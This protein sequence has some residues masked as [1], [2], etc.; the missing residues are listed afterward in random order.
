[1]RKKTVRD[2]DVRGKRALVRVDFNVPLDK[3]TRTVLDDTRIRAALPTIA[4]LR[5]QG[6]RVILCS[7][8]G[9]PD[10]H[11]KDDLR[12]KPV[13]DRLAE[14][15]GAPVQTASDCVG[16]E[17]EAAVKALDA[18]QV[19][20]LENLR[21][22]AE[23][24][25]NDP[26]FAQQ[27]AAL[28]DVYVNDAFGAAH[29]AHASTAGVTV[30]LP[31]VA[32][33]LMEKEI[34][35]LD[36]AVTNPD[37]PVAAIIGGA[38]I[39]SKIGVLRNLLSKV[40]IILIGGGMASTFLKAQGKA[41][42]DSLVEDDQLDTARA[43]MKRAAECGV[44]L[45]LPSDV[46]IADAFDERANAR[47]VSVDA[48]E[49]GWRIMDVGPATVRVYVDVLRG[50]K[51]I[52]W[53]GPLGVAEWEAFA[54]GSKAIARALAESDATTIVGGGETVALVEAAGLAGRF[55][56]V[57]TGGG[58]SLEFLEG[59]ELPGVAALLDAWPAETL[60]KE[61]EGR[62]MANPEHLALIDQGVKAVN[63]FV[64]ANEDV[65]IDLEG[66]D[67]SGRDLAGVRLQSA[68]MAGA[69]LR[70]CNLRDARF[71]STDLRDCDLRDADI[72]GA[73]FHRAD[74]T[75]ADLRGAKIDA[76]GVGGQRFCIAP[77]TFQQVRWDRED[78]ERML[79]I[80]NLNPDWEITWEV[81]P[82]R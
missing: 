74:L 27:L 10:G 66:A 33:F 62:A 22:H 71:N 59:K 14:L 57:S 60:S 20:L 34:D 56:H 2:V 26:E 9:R 31:A 52:I 54:G 70:G 13:A 46:V 49:Q 4:Y 72:R 25:A 79:E 8:L 50:M 16:P 55:S 44:R 35:Y 5:E 68:K 17:V 78:I 43:I 11:V 40:D 69:N 18:G 81:K 63:A 41:V 39:S 7:H 32:G 15:L 45:L 3:A 19:L 36:R 61:R 28:A 29:R 6:A 64:R 58:A 82:R 30:Y 75:G 80:I 37:R 48:V 51:T 76:I 65:A 21:F 67:L 47:T 12:L 77:A 42:G 38:K 1:M 24:E 73:S 53:N 23:E